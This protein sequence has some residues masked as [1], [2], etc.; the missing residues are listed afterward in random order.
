MIAVDFPLSAFKGA[1]IFRPTLEAK[2]AAARL[3]ALLATS[4][5]GNAAKLYLDTDLPLTIPQS[6]TLDGIVAR[7]DSPADE[8]VA[9]KLDL[10]GIVDDH[11][12]TLR[13]SA[14]KNTTEVD[15]TRDQTKAAIDAAPTADDATAIASAYTGR[16]I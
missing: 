16:T 9:V 10:D 14:G 5:E 13:Q 6:L 2:I 3:P 8:L 12:R 1:Q 11:A 7:L 4:T 15:T